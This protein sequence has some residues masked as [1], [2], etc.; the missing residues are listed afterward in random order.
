MKGISKLG[1]TSGSHGAFES[2]DGFEPYIS[3]SGLAKT[4][5][6]DVVKTTPKTV[7]KYIG[8]TG[9]KAG[10]KTT[11]G[12]KT[13]ISRGI[14]NIVTPG[15]VK[16]VG[17]GVRKTSV[18]ISKSFDN[19]TTNIK[20][21]SNG[22]IDTSTLNK[23]IK[24]DDNLL[25]SKNLKGS[26]T[27]FGV[28]TSKI[29]DFDALSSKLA[30]A[31]SFA[32]DLTSLSDDVGFEVKN[33]IDLT[34]VGRVDSLYDDIVKSMKLGDVAVTDNKIFMKLGDD[35]VDI[36]DDI[37]EDFA[38]ELA[39]TT[40]NLA[41]QRTIAR[42][43]GTGDNISGAVDKVAY[44]LETKIDDLGERIS[45]I[46]KKADDATDNIVDDVGRKV[47]D[48]VPNK[49]GRTA[50]DLTDASKVKK[51]HT[52]AVA[53]A[54]A[55]VGALSAMIIG[56]VFGKGGGDATASDE[57]VGACT[58]LCK[59]DATCQSCCEQAMTQYPTDT[60][61][62]QS[63][64]DKCMGGDNPQQNQN[65]N[66]KNGGGGN[67]DTAT[68]SLC[69]QAL[70]SGEITQLDYDNCVKCEASVG[71][72]ADAIS[73]CL[74]SS[75]SP[76][77]LH[78]AC[79]A[80]DFDSEVTR[81]YCNDCVDEGATTQDA[82]TSCI[83]SKIG[84]GGNDE[85]LLVYCE[86]DSLTDEQREQ[87][88]DCVNNGGV[89]TKDSLVDCILGKSKK[90]TLLAYCDDDGLTESQ[91]EF[92]IACANTEGVDTYNELKSCL[93]DK[94]ATPPV[95][96]DPSDYCK[97]DGALGNYSAFCTECVDSG[98]VEYDEIVSCIR[99]KVNSGEVTVDDLKKACDDANLTGDYLSQCYACAEASHTQE[100]LV[101]CYKSAIAVKPEDDSPLVDVCDPNSPLFDALTCQKLACD[102]SADY[103]DADLCEAI[104]A[105]NASSDI[106]VA[107]GTATGTV[108][109]YGGVVSAEGYPMDVVD[110]QAVPIDGTLPA[111]VVGLIGATGIGYGAYSEGYFDD[112]IS[113]IENFKLH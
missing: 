65:Q 107:D 99:D 81:Q 8:K 23:I 91:K 110:G 53:L 62:Q 4:G 80:A 103:Y 16:D 31:K 66:Q 64:F 82:V 17:I 5:L 25:S 48:G 72:D 50:D 102:Q 59:G 70:A 39:A 20:S 43:A 104:T 78:A 111:L 27:K 60:A 75:T 19:I 2:I 1:G 57:A 86:D 32:K 52:G 108:I 41:S 55:G 56:A 97:S 13:T 101:D 11:S 26:L 44:S 95:V 87:C 84:S 9:S 14:S 79:N 21:I 37:T 29:S 109:G 35:V 73:K 45:K 93:Q 6:V 68:E 49:I 106:S 40:D 36:T 112:I 88:I 69:D 34:D 77:D 105:Y 92:C 38:K 28:D 15:V 22:V 3:L 89:E 74:Q 42:L 58:D 54:A 63:A 33:V 18:G 94:L 71:S 7:I 100:E 61:G 30:S 113:R 76:E 51:P 83:K 85:S 12:L 90:T 24:L 46:G 96:D 47:D 67:G 98:L 10:I